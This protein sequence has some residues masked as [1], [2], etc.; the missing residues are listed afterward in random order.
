[1]H[2]GIFSHT[3]GLSQFKPVASRGMTASD[4]RH[5]DQDSMEGKCV[6]AAHRDDGGEV[7]RNS[8]A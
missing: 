2:S 6:N 3:P 7:W 1:M 8:N 4:Q 5:R